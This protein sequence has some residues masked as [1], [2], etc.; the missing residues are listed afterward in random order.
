MKLSKNT[1]VTIALAIIIGLLLGLIFDEGLDIVITIMCI[2]IIHKYIYIIVKRP[3][4]FL[5]KKWCL[6]TKK[7]ITRV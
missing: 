6:L 2:I 1:K 5:I 4:K 7:S 3:I